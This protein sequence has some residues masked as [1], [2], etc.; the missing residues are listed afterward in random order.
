MIEE[1]KRLWE[2]GPRLKV[3]D[4][5]FLG[6][7]PQVAESMIGTAERVDV[8]TV[9]LAQTAYLLVHSSLGSAGR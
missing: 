4:L 1:T 5:V 8:N 2:M 9:T 3:V 6:E 7:W